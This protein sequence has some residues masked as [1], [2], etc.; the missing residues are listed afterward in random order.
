MSEIILKNP[1][2][3]NRESDTVVFEA[4]VTVGNICGCLSN[5]IDISGLTVAATAAL[6]YTL[7]GFEAESDLSLDSGR[8][9]TAVIK[10]VGTI[11][12]V[13]AAEYAASSVVSA[14]VS[15][16]AGSRIIT[17]THQA[18]AFTWATDSLTNA[19]IEFSLPIK[20]K[21]F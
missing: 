19:V 21:D 17:V 16:T 3:K 9:G 11:G 12:A 14:I 5:T 2:F 7:S 8:R 6:T 18:A 15:G 1:A 10:A 13:T 4:L 20:Q